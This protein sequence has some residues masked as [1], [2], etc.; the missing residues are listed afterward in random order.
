MRKT[1]WL[2]ALAAVALSGCGTDA[3]E[4]VSF[5]RSIKDSPNKQITQ[6]RPGPGSEMA[7]AAPPGK[8]TPGHPAIT[9]SS[10]APGGPMPSIFRAD[11]TAIGKYKSADGATLEV[12]GVCR[13]TDDNVTC[14][15]LDGSDS[16][17]LVGF[18]KADLA[19][20]APANPYAGAFTF[21]FGRKNRIVIVKSTQPTGMV[22]ASFAIVGVGARPNLG[23]F[24]MQT[25]ES[26]VQGQTSHYELR[27]CAEDLKATTTTLH[28][29][30]YQ[31]AAP[32]KAID[33]RMGAN[34]AVNGETYTINTIVPQDKNT[35]GP[36]NG[37]PSWIIRFK[38]NRNGPSPSSV[39]LDFL[40]AS[41]HALQYVD[42]AGKPVSDEEYQRMIQKNS[43]NS[44]NEP[45]NVSTYRRARVQINGQ[46]D[47][48]YVATSFD[49]SLISKIAIRVTYS[50]SIDIAGIPLDP[51]H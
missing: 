17:D 29:L 30:E 16:K 24:G 39:Q 19:K 11:L 8:A 9:A 4:T 51:K 3:P 23:G 45:V 12:V 40:D 37:L 47:G 44:E 10:S 43:G 42:P 33:C 13:A 41:G 46:P 50:R 36:F 31:S 49:P 32:S 27:A 5:G 2:S 38:C 21:R 35:S 28:A 25:T 6:F 7:P 48:L 26:T 34:V 22:G 15:K 18:I 14:W 20:Q 1:A